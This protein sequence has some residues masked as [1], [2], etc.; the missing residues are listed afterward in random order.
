MKVITIGHYKLTATGLE[1][2]GRPSFAEHEA[3]GVF[4]ARSHHA[5]GLWL[6]DWLR[7]GDSRKD[8]AA[9]LDAAQEATGLSLKSLRNIRA[10]GAVPQHVRREGL[11]MGHYAQVV[12]L[13]EGEQDTWLEQAASEN[14]TV[15]DLQLNVRA[16]KRRR[17]IDGKA[18]LEG[19][20]RVI[21]ADPPW[22]YGSSIGTAGTAA[23]GASDKY[24][25]MD[26]FEIGNLPVEAH[27]EADAVLFMWVTSPLLLQSPGPIDVGR[28]WG[29]EYKSSI[30]WDKVLGNFGNYVRVHHEILTI[31]TRGRCLPDAPTPQPDSVQTIRRSDEHSAKPEEFRKLITKLYTH[32]PYLELF[33]RSRAPGWT[34][35]GNDARLWATEAAEA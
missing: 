18:K 16:S 13:T 7:Y 31:W 17:V 12:G 11:E 27:A 34:S 19:Q 5:S 14:M 26:I 3:A 9:K 29:F 24:P 4:I 2:S 20:Y 33:A 1:I 28:A 15:R 30:V 6:A 25:T 10:I 22:S 32:G 8:W 35:F 21:Y 23:R